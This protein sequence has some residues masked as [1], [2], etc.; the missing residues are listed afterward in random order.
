MNMDFKI[1]A[2]QEIRQWESDLKKYLGELEDAAFKC[3]EMIKAPDGT[4]TFRQK[5][6]MKLLD[7]LFIGESCEMI[8]ICVCKKIQ[9]LGIKMLELEGSQNSSNRKEIQ[10]LVET[11]W[12]YN[13]FA[14]SVRERMI[15][16][17][18]KMEQIAIDEHLLPNLTN[19]L[20]P[21]FKRIIVVMR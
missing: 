2:V 17:F 19:K 1:R 9:H 20:W 3:L 14:E 5:A 6:E 11:L 13:L 12:Q 21:Q 15:V 8:L 4:D 16:F 7:V 10:V 18:K